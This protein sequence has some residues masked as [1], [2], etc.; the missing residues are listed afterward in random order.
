M[1]YNTER[2]IK[3]TDIRGQRRRGFTLIELLVVISIIGILVGLMLPTVQKSRFAAQ[4]AEMKD[5]LHTTVYANIKT[6]FNRYRHYPASL[7]DPNFTSLFDPRLIDPQTHALS[8]FNA[9]G[10]F[11]LTYTAILAPD[12]A[13]INFELCASQ[14]TLFTRPDGAYGSLHYP[15]YCMDKSHV[16]TTIQPVQP[17]P[18]TPVASRQTTAAAAEAIV[19]LLDANPAL[20][21]QARTA[22]TKYLDGAAA[23]KFVFNLLDADHNGV[24]TLAELDRNPVS[25][26]F[27]SF[28]HSDGIFARQIDA[29]ISGQAG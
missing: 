29:K 12:G 8:Y 24:V 18:L 27:G 14:G 17:L 5:Q 9:L 28:Y 19:P 3:F 25:A 21:P 22:G 13:P 10:G 20:I 4:S 11:T 15:A 1:V 2:S 26:L 7:A 23:T 16:V 6:Y